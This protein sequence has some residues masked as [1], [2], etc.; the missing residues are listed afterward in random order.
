[1]QYKVTKRQIEYLKKVSVE[2]EANKSKYLKE[3]IVDLKR[4][5]QNNL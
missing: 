3:L 5:T 1:V 4:R 2:N